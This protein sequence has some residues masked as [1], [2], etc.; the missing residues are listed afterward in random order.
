MNTYSNDQN[1]HVF[2]TFERSHSLSKILP[3]GGGFFD[4]AMPTTLIR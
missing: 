4:E 3:D 2:E 1:V